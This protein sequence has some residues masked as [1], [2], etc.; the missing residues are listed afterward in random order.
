MK[1][2]LKIIPI[3]CVSFNR[4]FIVFT[5]EVSGE[6]SNRT[7]SVF[8]NRKFPCMLSVCLCNTGYKE[9]NFIKSVI[10]SFCFS[11]FH[12]G[13]SLEKKLHLALTWSQ[14]DEVITCF[15]YVYC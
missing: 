10:M 5:A 12:S 4:H 2:L 15:W 13:D 9:G 14:R 6:M 11:L 3:L 8:K 7:I 1:D